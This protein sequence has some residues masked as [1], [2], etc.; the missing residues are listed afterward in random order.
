[1]RF[2]IFSILLLTMSRHHI[3]NAQDMPVYEGMDLGLTYT[4]QY[5]TFKVWSPTAQKV[6]LRFYKEGLPTADGKDLIATVEMT[7]GERG[8]WQ[9]TAQGDRK[10]Q[11]YTFQ[12]V[13]YD[14]PSKEVPDIYAKAV[15]ANGLRAQVV[16]LKTTNP[17]G[18]RATVCLILFKKRTPFYMSFMCAM[19]L[20][21]TKQILKI[22]ENF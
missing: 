12:F 16:D 2:F 5:S 22:K 4:P 11:F 15:G 21:L 18:G 8:I 7:K 20:F 1:M 17:K 10:G 9:H 14:I 19:P 3:L 6:T 13:N